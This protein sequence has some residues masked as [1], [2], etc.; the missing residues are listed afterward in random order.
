[1]DIHLSEYE[2][3]ARAFRGCSNPDTDMQRSP[4]ECGIDGCGLSHVQLNAFYVDDK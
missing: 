1:M 2:M 3:A 4:N